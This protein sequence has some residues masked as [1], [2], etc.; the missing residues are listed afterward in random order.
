[1]DSGGPWY[2]KPI[3][4]A[5]KPVIIRIAQLIICFINKG[6]PLLRNEKELAF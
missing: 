4:T 1:V 5:A 6:L 3:I 2:K